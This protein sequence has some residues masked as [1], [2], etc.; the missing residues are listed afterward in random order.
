MLLMSISVNI[1]VLVQEKDRLSDKGRM[2]LEM[3]EEYFNK[4]VQKLT[5]E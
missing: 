5:E 3:L 4:L 1:N 2:N